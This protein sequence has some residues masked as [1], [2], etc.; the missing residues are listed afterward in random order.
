MKYKKFIHSKALIDCS[1]AFGNNG[2]D[3]G[4]DFRSYQWMMKHGGLPTEDD[5]GNYL[6]QVLIIF[7]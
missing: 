5:Y 4:E 6:G 1:W 7:Y 3:G 2:C